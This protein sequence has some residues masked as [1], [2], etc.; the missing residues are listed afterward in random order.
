MTAV[1]SAITSFVVTTSC[2]SA[3]AEA[4]VD[5]CSAKR[6]AWTGTEPHHI[7]LCDA[8]A[9]ELPTSLETSPNTPN[10]DYGVGRLHSPI[11]RWRNLDKP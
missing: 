8:S 5:G 1:T 11:P 3:G 4:G 7:V 2:E 9:T 6:I 10:R